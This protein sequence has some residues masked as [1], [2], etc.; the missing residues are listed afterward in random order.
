MVSS[1]HVRVP[2]SPAWIPDSTLSI[3]DSRYWISDFVSGK[4]DSWFQSLMGFRIPWTVFRIFQS[5]RFRIPQAKI[6][7]IRNPDFLTCGESPGRTYVLIYKQLLQ[8]YLRFLPLLIAFELL[9]ATEKKPW[10]LY[11]SKTYYEGLMFGGAYLLREICVSES[12]RLA[13]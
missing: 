2:D 7:G 5:R 12:I 9:V 11:F 8:N 4:L 1:L 10:G 3:P 13:L 6:L